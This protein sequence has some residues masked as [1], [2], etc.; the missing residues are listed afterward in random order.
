[1]THVPHDSPRDVRA[2]PPIR[3]LI[4]AAARALGE[5][6]LTDDALARHVRPLFSRVLKRPGIYLAN[7][8]L[9]RPLDCMADDV[10]GALDDWYTQLDDAWGPWMDAIARFRTLVASLIGL[11]DAQCIAPKTSAGQGLRAVLSALAAKHNGRPLNIIATTGEFDSI[12]FILR[13]HHR[14]GRARLSWVPPRDSGL[15]DARDIAHAIT[16]ASSTAPPDLVVCSMVVF[17]TGQLLTDLPLVRAAADKAGALWLLDLYHAAG[18]MPLDLTEL[19]PDFAIGGSY[20]YLRGGPGA[21]WL[22]LHPRVLERSDLT[23]LDTGW[24]AKDKPFDFAPGEHARRAQ[25]GDAW[26][27]STPPVLTVFQ[28]LAGMEL[29][30]AITPA[31]LRAHNLAQQEYLR[32]ALRARSVPAWSFEP[33]GAYTLVPVNPSA[34]DDP[35]QQPHHP[36][37]A[38]SIASELARRGVITDARLAPNGVGVVRLCPDILTTR[39]EMDRAAETLSAILSN[40]EPRSIPA[41]L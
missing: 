38:K 37:D 33:H 11:P 27:E 35:W 7:H 21:C 12:D 1:M 24:F 22:A 29:A 2:Q 9:G 26:L 40:R 8:S 28:A 34:R 30:L 3:A 31:R 20:K 4:A 19:A 25:G 39:Q 17:S 18:A 41:A 23:T 14:L 5:G 15:F 6:P 16:S 36:R 10:R 13:E 32:D